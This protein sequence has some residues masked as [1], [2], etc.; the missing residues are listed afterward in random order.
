MSRKDTAISIS[1]TLVNSTNNTNNT[2]TLHPRLSTRPLHRT[3]ANL[4]TL[5]RMAGLNTGIKILNATITLNKPQAVHS[6]SRH[7]ASITNHRG[8]HHHHTTSNDIPAITHEVTD[9]E[10]ITD[11]TREA[12]D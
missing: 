4:L 12:R 9:L 2:T 1:S 6:G 3:M 7:Q 8:P 5:H 10:S 11:R